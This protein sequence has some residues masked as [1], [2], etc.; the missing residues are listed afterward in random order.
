[1]ISVRSFGKTNEGLEAQ[2]FILDNGNMSVYITD[3]GGH[4]V[5]INVPD[6]DGVMTDVVLGADNVQAYAG[7]IDYMGAT[8]GR[9]ANRIEGG[10]FELNGKE[11]TLAINNGP[12]HLHGGIDGFNHKMFDA[13]VDGETLKLS[14]LSPDGEEGYPGNLNFSVAFTL[15]EDN[16]LDIEYNAESDADTVIN[17]TNHTY[18]NLNGAL[19][20]KNIYNHYLMINAEA[21]CRGDKDCLADGTIVSVRNTDMDFRKMA[22]LGD[23]IN[24]DYEDIAITDG[25]D[26]NFVLKMS[27]GEYTKAAE[28]FCKETGIKL[29]CYTDQP[30]IQIYTGNVTDYKGG[31]C[32]CYY[33]KHSA[34]CLETQ[35]FPNS[36]SFSYFPSP[37]LKAGENFY[38]KTSY[39]FS[40]EK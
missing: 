21:F 19:S 9:F 26:H 8:I 32:G 22:L 5:A 30:G 34:I 36:T 37:V 16:T 23:R 4:I 2:L 33:G 20:E 17:F 25:I 12:N 10:K 15:R 31:K 39:K 14:Y 7:N 40:V 27:R 1:M 35:T 24:S 29:Q 28:L 18:F 13:F 38:S 3:F 6:K 11:Y